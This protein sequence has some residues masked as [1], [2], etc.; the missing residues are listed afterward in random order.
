MFA[1]LDADTNDGDAGVSPTFAKGLLTLGKIS[2]G[3]VK[4]RFGRVGGNQKDIHSKYMLISPRYGEGADWEQL[5]FTGSPNFTKDGLVDGDEVM[6][7][8]RDKRIMAD[9]TDNFERLWSY[10]A[11]RRRGEHYS[12]SACL[13][14][15]MTLGAALFSG[16]LCY[17]FDGDQYIRVVRGDVGAGLFDTGRP[18]AISTWGWPDGFGSSGIDAALSSGGVAESTFGQL[19]KCYFFDG[20]EYV[21][22]TRGDVGAGTVDPGYPKPISNWGWPGGFGSNG[23]DAALS[24]GVVTEGA[25]FQPPSSKCYFFDGDQYIRVTR[26]DV[27]AGTVDPGYPKP[28]SNW[29]WPG[30][31]GSNGIDAALYSGSKC[32]FFD[33]DQYIR[34]TRGDVG[35]GTVDPGYPRPISD[36]GWPAGF[37]GAPGPT[38]RLHVKVLT[39]PSAAKIATWITEHARPFSD[40]WDQRCS[41]QHRDLHC[42]HPAQLQRSRQP[43]R[44]QL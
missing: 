27:G 38:V 9:Y 3:R 39:G 33:G 29:G 1:R 31:F 40:G 5:V 26:G 16:P 11:S 15:S 20:D 18:R 37:A 12:C 13:R 35:A 36:W 14:T 30:G 21:R 8:I 2:F 28:I 22:V 32:Y 42:G 17:F 4:V 10:C 24:S 19:S 43:Q 7:K 23:I 34:V 6:I 41:G 44:R 25:G